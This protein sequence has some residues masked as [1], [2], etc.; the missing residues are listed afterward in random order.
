MAVGA[1]SLGRKPKGPLPQFAGI[2]LSA[3]GRTRTCDPRLRRPSEWS[4]RVAV[5]RIPRKHGGFAITPTL[6]YRLAVEA[7]L[8]Q[9]WIGRPSA[10]GWWG[11]SIFAGFDATSKAFCGPMP[12]TRPVAR[13]TPRVP[14]NAITTR[15]AANIAKVRAYAN[16]ARCMR[17]DILLAS[18]AGKRQRRARRAD[19]HDPGDVHCNGHDP[20]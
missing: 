9:S 13:P 14:S 17:T 5:R 8:D 18:K 19:D 4:R 10:F 11:S 20:R 7:M 3:P 15:V 12:P 2:S 6:G 1:S 16:G